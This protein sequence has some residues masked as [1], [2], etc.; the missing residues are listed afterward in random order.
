VYAND[1]SIVGGTTG[2]FGYL[3]A[4]EPSSASYTPNPKRNRA[5]SGFTHTVTRSG[6][7]QYQAQVY[8][9]LKVP[10]ALH[11]SV[12]GNTDASCDLVRWSVRPNTQPAGLVDVSCFDA[13]GVPA[14]NVFSLNYYSPS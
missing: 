12:N 8:G 2:F 6:P 11:V 4:N 9:P 7:G 3:Q 13:A 5:P 10:V 1:R 14:D